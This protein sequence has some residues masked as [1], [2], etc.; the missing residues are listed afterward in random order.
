MEEE[1]NKEL[2]FL[3]EQATSLQKKIDFLKKDIENLKQKNLK[4][5]LNLK[6]MELRN[7]LNFKNNLLSA[8]EKIE[9]IFKEFKKENREMAENIDKMHY[10]CFMH[11]I[12]NL[13]VFLNHSLNYLE[14]EFKTNL[15]QGI[16]LKPF[17]F[18]HGP[19]IKTI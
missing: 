4:R 1:L 10:I 3:N 15:K 5:V 18:L 6:E 13:E 9:Y 12:S 8:S 19:Q 16:R 2:V 11:G 7:L 17:E 14:K